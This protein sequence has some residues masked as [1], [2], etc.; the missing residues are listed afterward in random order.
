M[1]RGELVKDIEIGD[2]AG[3]KWLNS[4]CLS[5]V[6]CRQSH[7]PLCPEAQLSGYTVD[8]SFQQYAVARAA[9]VA[10]IPKDLSLE[11]VAPVLCAGITVYK[12]LKESDARAG[13]TVAI[14]G[15]GGGL[16]N[17]ALQYAKAM[18]LRTIGID[19]GTDK[20]EACKKLG[21]AAF[22]DFKTSKDL[23]ADVKAAT[24]DGL[25]PDAVL[26]L[27]VSE[28]PFQQAADYVRPGGSI[29]CIGLPTNAY[30]KAPVFDTVIKMIKIKGSYVGNRQDTAEAIDFFARGLIKAP[31]KVVGLSELKSVFDKMKEMKVVGRYVVDTSR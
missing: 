31:Y 2:H 25:G 17:M 8:G 16:G 14:V 30:L 6:Y 1:A 3:I 23:V 24:S 21:A 13:Q 19:A 12:G 15:A 5:C 27:A 22:V 28:G 26:L 18:G 20:E 4:S 7:E 11:A 10:R 29:V 9:H